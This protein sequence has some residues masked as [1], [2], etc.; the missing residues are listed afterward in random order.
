MP[1]WVSITNAIKLTGKSENTI[2]RLI[3][4]TQKTNKELATKVI[5]KSP[6]GAYQIETGFL[7]NKYPLHTSEQP[8]SKKNGIPVGNN[9]STQ[10]DTQSLDP[11]IKAKDETISILKSQLEKQAT[12]YKEQLN[13][14]DEQTKMLLERMREN[15]I[16]LQGLALPMPQRE[17]PLE[18]LGVV[19]STNESNQK[20][21][22]DVPM[23]RP[24][25]QPKMQDMGIK[26]E[27]RSSTG[28]RIKPKSASSKS[29][30][31]KSIKTELLKKKGIFSF[32]RGK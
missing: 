1:Q 16:I 32:F 14:K 9:S 5:T 19:T 11:I 7:Y 12:E 29:Q 30:R 27:Q 6:T 8:M 15:N 21:T 20:V 3:Y 18:P 26:S 10:S 23:D 4:E 28:K 2:R 24:T 31:S 22:H 13:R 17:K 25:E